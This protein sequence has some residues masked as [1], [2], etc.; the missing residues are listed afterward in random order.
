MVFDFESVLP[1]LSILHN[2]DDECSHLDA[3]ARTPTPSH[4]HTLRLAIGLVVATSSHGVVAEAS[5]DMWRPETKPFAQKYSPFA[6]SYPE[7]PSV[8]IVKHNLLQP[9]HSSIGQKPKGNCY[10][11]NRSFLFKANNWN[12]WPTSTQF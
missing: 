5:E 7:R 8:P 6:K 2:G 9:E 10:I 4:A 12:E 1:S 3:H 11:A